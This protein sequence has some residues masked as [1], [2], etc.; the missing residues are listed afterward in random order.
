V[1][2]EAQNFIRPVKGTPLSYKKM[3]RIEALLDLGFSKEALS[4]MVALSGNTES[5][6]DILYI[7]SKMQE[8]GEYKYLV[9][10]VRKVPY[11]EE[12]HQFLYPFAYRDI[13]EGLS[14]KYSIDPLL[15]LSVMREESRFDADAR[16]VA[17]ALGLMQ[18]MPQ[19]AFRF[20]N[21]L[22]LGID[23][24]RDILK[25]KNNLH[26]GSYY[27]S[28]LVKEFGSYTYALAAYNAGEDIVR[29]WLQKGNYKSPDE[30]IED[31]PYI[32]TKNY[33]KRVLTTFF[34]YKRASATGLTIGKIS[35]EKL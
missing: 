9:G 8:L 15:V 19:T 30:F 6:E 14:K 10:L 2:S 18:I 34:E 29:K 13:I 3:N 4:E 27:L 5:I 11:R 16:S 23:N 31:I 33:V 32:E 1:T 17:G 12:L 24:S 25:V 22:G 7:C 20:D 21:T 28:R 26:L 35:S